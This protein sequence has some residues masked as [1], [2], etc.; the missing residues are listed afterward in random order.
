MAETQ[1]AIINAAYM[2]LKDAIKTRIR[3]DRATRHETET[4][5]GAAAR[6]FDEGSTQVAT[7]AAAT[8][9]RGKGKVK[10]KPKPKATAAAAKGKGSK[11]SKGTTGEQFNGYCNFNSALCKAWGHRREDCFYNPQGNSYKGDAWVRQQEETA[12]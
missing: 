7:S 10:S 12:R 8:K 5:K 2:T 4:K 6:K 9:G 1:P 3:I 11:G